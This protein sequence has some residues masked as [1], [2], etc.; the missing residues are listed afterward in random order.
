MHAVICP[1]AGLS[2]DHIRL[3][4]L[5]AKDRLVEFCFIVTREGAGTSG[6]NRE[7]ILQHVDGASAFVKLGLLPPDEVFGQKILDGFAENPLFYRS[8]ARRP[9]G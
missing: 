2:K 1:A 7:G 4:K 3:G 6:S 9:E 8:P 5:L